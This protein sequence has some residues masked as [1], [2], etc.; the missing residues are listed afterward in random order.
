MKKLYS[1]FLAVIVAAHLMAQAPHFPLFE[2]FSQASCTPCAQQNPTFQS[3]ILNPNPLVVRHITYHTSWP[4]VDPMY[5]LNTTQVDDRVNY[6]GI[7]GVPTVVMLGNHKTGGPASFLQ[8]DVDKE[9]SQTS[10]V[11]ISVSN[12]DNG[13]SDSATITL[14]VLGN[15][16]SGNYV[17]R[18]AV[19]ER[20]VN[21][22]TAPGTN[23]EL[24]FPDV[25]RLMLPGSGGDAVTLPAIGQT[26][27]FTYT[28][29]ENAAWNMNEIGLVA[30]LE[31]ELTHEVINCGSTFDPVIDATITSP[32]LLSQLGTTG[33]TSTFNFTA[34]NSG[35]ASEDFIYTLST[36]APNDWS[37]SFNVGSNNYTNSATITVAP[38]ATNNVSINVMPGTTPAFATYT[39]TITSVQY[40]NSPAMTMTVFVVSNVTDLIVNSTGGMG[41]GT[42]GGAATWQ[43]DYTTALAATGVT[44]WAITNSDNAMR[45]IADGALT[46]VRNMY[47]NVGWTFPCLDDN[48]VNNLKTY[49]DAG[50][51]LFMAGQD[52]AWSVFDA[53]NS[54]YSSTNNM[55]FMNNYMGVN[56]V[57]DGTTANNMLNAET[58]DAIFGSVASSSILNYYGGAYF[59]PDE[60]SAFGTGIPVFHY[61]SAT[62]F[63]GIR[64]TNG[65]HKSVH[66]GVGLEMINDVSVKNMIISLS[67]QWFEGTLSAQQFDNA[68]AQLGQNYP[69]PSDAS[70]TIPVTVSQK[71]NSIILMDVLGRVVTNIPLCVGTQNINILT[72]NLANG[73]YYYKIVD[74]N[75]ESKTYTLQVSH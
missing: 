15:L 63:A 71:N 70:T 67:R 43:A 52:V 31:N 61:V 49:M 37:G 11:K 47:Y 7:T 50:G 65:T 25:F 14:L 4:G 27:T 23:G 10:P 18:T 30:F 44:T 16:P 59:Y 68:L 58:G 53:T 35:N 42:A 3:T 12:I 75:S 2:H 74:G 69:N 8:S 33:G 48:V 17:M 34:G 26:A 66:L 72:A 39:L 54:P 40:P 64:N 28:F 55:D 56:W 24:Y 6:Y 19:I 21:Y 20:N 1:L 13:T 73:V 46:N 38:G 36:D 22:T 5:N 60:L 29:N 45:A 9:W 51:D 62:K 57:A 41:D 32:T